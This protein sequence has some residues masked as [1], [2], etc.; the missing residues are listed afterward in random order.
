MCP[1]PLVRPARAEKPAVAGCLRKPQNH[2]KHKD[3]TITKNPKIFVFFVPFVVKFFR[4]K[5]FLPA[6]RI[7]KEPLAYHMA[8]ARTCLAVPWLLSLSKGPS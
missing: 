5:E 2:L 8:S 4:V 3:T 6:G 1:G 7:C